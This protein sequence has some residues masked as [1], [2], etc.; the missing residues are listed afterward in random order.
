MELDLAIYN[1]PFRAGDEVRISCASHYGQIATIVERNGLN[2]HKQPLWIVRL[3]DG[4]ETTMS[5]WEGWLETVIV[6]DTRDYLKA[7]TEP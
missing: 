5:V 4:K 2:P 7:I 1:K 6:E 3:D